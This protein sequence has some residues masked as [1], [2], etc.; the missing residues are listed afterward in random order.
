MKKIFTPEFWSQIIIQVLVLGLILFFL[1]NY[2][3]NKWAPLTAAETLKKENFLNA[4][5]DTYFEAI[6][7]LNRVLANASF[8]VDG[9]LADT[10]KR[11]PGG[12]YPTDLE[13]NKCF[14][15]L[16][17]YSDN[18]EI[19]LVYQRI[20]IGNNPN[21]KPVFEMVT[22]VNLVRKDLGY[23]SPI[24]DTSGDSYKFIQTHGRGT[25]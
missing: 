9:K 22:F 18:S 17:I 7:L 20:F 19:P 3:K 25:Q 2:Y 13:I 12:H 14:S 16:C 15:K 4:K 8:T 11:N 23:G 5:R 1:Q 6:D 24:I 21:I 10:S